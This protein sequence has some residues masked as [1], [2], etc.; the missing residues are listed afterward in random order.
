VDIIV[1]FHSNIPHYVIGYIIATEDNV[2]Y[3]SIMDLLDNE[4]APD[5]DADVGLDPKYF[6]KVELEEDD[7]GY[8]SIMDLLDKEQSP[9]GADTD[10]GLDP[11]YF[12]KQEL[13]H[14]VDHY[15]MLLDNK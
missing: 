6:V 2:W 11:K 15:S 12:V 9:N 14:D 3:D 4:Q 10:E 13:K 1:I 8:D 7:V 5:D